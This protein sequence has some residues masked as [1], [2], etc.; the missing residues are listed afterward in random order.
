MFPF[1]RLVALSLAWICTAASLAIGP[2]SFAKEPTT[3]TTNLS[4]L[5][6]AMQ[7][8]SL[9]RVRELIASGAD[10]NAKQSDGMTALHWAC[11]HD[12]PQA[13]AALIAA[14]ANVDAKNDYDIPPLYIGCQNGNVEIVK[15]LLK[16]GADAKVTIP[17]GETCLMVASRTGIPEV[18][19]SLL[20]H[21]ADP[22]A[23]ERK[24]Q[25]AILWAAA[26]GNGEVVDLLIDAGA[27]YKT[28]LPSGFTPM[29][30]AIREGQTDVVRRLLA[31]AVD[32]N[33]PMRPEK[34]G[35]GG[36]QNGMSPLMM[37]VENGHFELAEM[38]LENGA[39]PND[40][41]SGYTALHALTWVR[42]PIR[43]DGDPPPIG[44]GK[45]TSLDL[46]RTL[47]AKG[48]D[49]NARHGK[50][51]PANSAL[52]K[53]D[54]TPF[55][56]ACE[57]GDVPLMRLLLESGAD[58][59]IT[60]ADNVT[61]L[62]AAAGVGVLGNG[63]D[64]AGTEEDAIEAIQLLLDLGADINAVDAEGKTAMHGAA[65]QSWNN[66]VR[67]LHERGAKIA[68]WNRKN[69][70]GWTPLM[71]AQGNRPGNFRPSP[72]TIEAVEAVMR[73]CGVQPPD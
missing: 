48:A 30:F 22:N 21:G 44:S 2:L 31:R 37:A 43:G 65:F 64:S 20:D 41:R 16:A 57:T 34:R 10:I 40:G 36:P 67:L 35:G 71:I 11:Y 4:P 12:D 1:R 61:P 52:N 13:T 60:N 73:A 14:G 27:D 19:K 8:K 24:G 68:I 5:A 50:H 3:Q 46:V 6:D 42:K 32:V 18:V 49:V 55:L 63:D 29:T 26:E 9:G 70:L 28:P 51:R 72:E 33:E 45:R 59:T 39:D 69:N 54:A 7:A 53:T 47:I 15:S 58:P 66:L 38:L 62:L 25:T 23:R 17:G 56:L